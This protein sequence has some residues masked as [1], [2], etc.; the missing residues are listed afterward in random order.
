VDLL[1]VAA[2][3]VDPVDP[4]RW[5][6]SVLAVRNGVVRKGHGRRLK[7]EVLRLAREAGAREVVSVVHE[8]N[9]AMH[10]LNVSLG[11]KIQRDRASYEDLDYRIPL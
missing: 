10:Q 5:V 11:A 6:S 9:E 1:G 2:W 4:R 8:K 3:S 7:V